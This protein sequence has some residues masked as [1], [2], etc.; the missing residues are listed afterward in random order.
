MVDHRVHVAGADGEEEPRPAESPPV[1]SGPPVR[2]GYDADPE[3]GRFEHPAEDRHGEAR[4]VD[5]GVAGHEDDVGLAPATMSHFHHGH[6][7]RS[8]GGTPF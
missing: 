7:E 3:A 4:V 8:P 5:V 2:L 1:V 6:G